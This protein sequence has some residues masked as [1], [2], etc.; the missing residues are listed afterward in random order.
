MVV[1]RFNLP[2]A[3]KRHGWCDG[4]KNDD[5]VSIMSGW[6]SWVNYIKFLKCKG[7]RIDVIGYSYELGDSI[8]RC[9]Q[10]LAF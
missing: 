3:Y 5:C 7:E 1:S 8:G 2:C 10:Y 9:V 6:V 4:N